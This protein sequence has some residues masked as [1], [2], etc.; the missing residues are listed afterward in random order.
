M[1]SYR[2]G[3]I[4]CRRNSHLVTSGACCEALGAFRMAA[5]PPVRSGTQ[6]ASAPA[7][8]DLPGAPDLSGH[9]TSPTARSAASLTASTGRGDLRAGAAVTRCEIENRI[10]RTPMTT[11]L[12]VFALGLG[13]ALLF[14]GRLNQARRRNLESYQASRAQPVVI[15]A[16]RPKRRPF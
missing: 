11:A 9:P 7:E 4:N 2:E 1:K 8:H 10:G 6:S 13:S 14:I 15:R 5:L 3:P 16:R 12:I